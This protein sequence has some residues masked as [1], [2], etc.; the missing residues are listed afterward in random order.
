M[1]QISSADTVMTLPSDREIVI[2]RVFDAPR[3]LVF[4]AMTKPEHVKRWYGPSYLTLKS[5][6]IDFRVGGKWRYVLQGPD[7]NDFAFSG[8]YREIV[9]P[10]RVVNTEGFEGLPGHEALVTVTFDEVDGKT[11]LTSH[12]QYDS[13]EDRDGHIQSGMEG[14]MRETMD[15]LAAHIGTMQ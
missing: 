14:G 8:E 6:E 4:D 1:N 13:V 12:L 15:R 10:E 7:G 9:T 5:C 3:R 2:T 11:R